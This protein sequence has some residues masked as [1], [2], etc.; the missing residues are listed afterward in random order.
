MFLNS[1]DKNMMNDILS[2][3]KAI[4][5]IAQK[6][7]EEKEKAKHKESIK[8]F[9]SYKSSAV[10]YRASEFKEILRISKDGNFIETSQGAKVSVDAAKVLY[11]M[12][13]A[14]R[15]IKGHNIDGYTVISINGVL[16][17]GCHKIDMKYVHKIGK[18]LINL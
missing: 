12:I 14:K 3:Q 1:Y 17:I 8:H 2:R 4:Q 5:D 15:D 11:L 18:K 9:L 10:Y 13:Q 16:T 7:K 6:A